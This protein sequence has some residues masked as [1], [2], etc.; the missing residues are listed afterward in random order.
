MPLI[1][2]VNDDT[3]FLQLMQDALEGEGYRVRLHFTT[4]GVEDAIAR[5]R[6]DLMVLDIVMDL[7]DAGLRLLRAIRGRRGPGDLPV[8]VCSADVA[9]LRGHA[10]ELAAL[11]CAVVEKPFELDALLA[12]VAAMIRAEPDA[13]GG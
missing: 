13:G 4:D 7:R 6:P 1:A 10:G 8:I 12:R 9:F 2:V 3:A 5:E 11:G